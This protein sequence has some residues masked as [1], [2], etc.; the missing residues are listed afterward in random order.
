MVADVPWLH[1]P[2]PG[3]LAAEQRYGDPGGYCSDP[4]HA[5]PYASFPVTALV[6]RPGQATLIHDHITW[7][8]FGVIQGA[9]HERRYALRDDGRLEQ[10][11]VAAGTAAIRAATA[12]RGVPGNADA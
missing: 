5:E 9:E 3:I 6:W 7:C 1:M 8:V 2:S 11:G 12:G 10:D 4:L